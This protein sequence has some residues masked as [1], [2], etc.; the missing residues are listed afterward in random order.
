MTTPYKVCNVRKFKLFFSHLLNS[1][2]SFLDGEWERESQYI[3]YAGVWKIR[4]E[5]MH[6][7]SVCHSL[8]RPM[9]AGQKKILDRFSVCKNNKR[10]NAKLKVE[11]SVYK[12]WKNFHPLALWS[13]LEKNLCPIWQLWKLQ[14]DKREL[15]LEVNFMYNNNEFNNYYLM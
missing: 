14:N 15:L 4:L 7:T 12:S 11:S 5:K 8:Q 1:V 2:I 9:A 13:S 6:W 10:K 3:L